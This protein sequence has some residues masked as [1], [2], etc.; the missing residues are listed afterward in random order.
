MVRSAN[1]QPI[2]EVLHACALLDS[3]DSEINVVL[4]VR[5]GGKLTGNFKG[6]IQKGEIAGHSFFFCE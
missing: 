2:I 6:N 3:F 4:I 1:L 5:L